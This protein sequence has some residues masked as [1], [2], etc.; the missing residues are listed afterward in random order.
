MAIFVHPFDLRRSVM[1]K[2][3]SCLMEANMTD[4]LTGHDVMRGQPQWLVD[5]ILQTS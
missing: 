3:I 5:I 1:A 2:T 4:R